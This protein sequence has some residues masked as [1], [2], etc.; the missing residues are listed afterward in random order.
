MYQ[1]KPAEIHPLPKVAL[2][3]HLLNPMGGGCHW[4]KVQKHPQTRC[5]SCLLEETRERN[6]WPLR[7][8]SGA[9]RRRPALISGGGLVGCDCQ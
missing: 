6:A 8:T 4:E 2:I 9:T 7:K 1:K 3:L 5:E